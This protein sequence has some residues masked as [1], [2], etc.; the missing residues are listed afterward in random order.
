MSPVDDARYNSRYSMAVKRR[1]CTAETREKVLKDIQDWAQDSNAARVYWMNG[2]AGTGKTTILY[3]LCEWLAKEQRLG[4]NY[5]CSRG[6]SSCR[7]VN[8]IVPTLAYQLARYSPAFR[9]ALCKVLEEN[10]E[11]SALDVKWQF[12][13]LLQEPMQAVN[14]AMPEGV[15]IVIDGLDECDDGE[16]FRLFLE[17]ALKL[18]ADLPI[19]FFLASRPEPAIREKMLAPGYWYSILHLHD[20]EES[21]VEHDIKQYLTEALGSLYPPPSPN[22]VERLA[23]RA[24]KLFIYAATVVRYI[25]N[26]VNSSR[27]LQTVLGL[28][29]EHRSTKQHDEL[30]TLYTGILSTAI[31]PERLEGQ[32]MD[33]IWL[34]LKTVVCAKELMTVETLGSL[35]HVTEEQ[36]HSSLEPLRSIL[37]IQDIPSGL[38][39]PFHASFPDYL[40]DKLRSGD[41]HCEMT[42]H[43]DV[44]ATCCFDLMKD[45]L[46]FNICKLES[47]FVFDRDV[48]DLQDQIK[49]SIPSAL[50]YACQYWGEH[51]RQGDFTDMVHTRLIDFLTHR[52]LFWMEVLNLEQHLGIGGHMLQQIQNWLKKDSYTNTQKQIADAEAFITHFAGGACSWS[53]P[54]IYISGLAFCPKSSSVYK[55]YWQHTQGLIDIRGSAMEQWPSTAIGLWKTDSI[56]RSVAFSPNGT[57]IASGSDDHTIQ[58]WDAHT[59]NTIAGP[60]RGHTNSVNSVAFS[61]DGAYIVSGSSDNTIRVWDISTGN[62][63]AGSFKGHTNRVQSVAFSPNGTLIVSG[64]EDCTIRVWDAYTGNTVAGP[65]KEHTNSV[66]SVTFSPE[67]TY[68]VSGS[69]DH[70]IRIWNTYNGSTI[71]GP[72][73]GHTN[74]VSSVAFSPDGTHIVSG[75]L[76]DTIRVWSLSTGDIVAGPFK[77]HTNWVNSVAF[78]PNGKHIVSGSSDQTIQV[79]DIHTGNNIAG[80]F[81]GHTNSVSSVAFSPSGTHIVSGSHDHTIQVWDA[82]TSSNISG[83]VKGHTD[84]VHSVAFSSDSTCIASGSSDNTVQVWDAFTGA[85]IAGPFKGHKNWINSVAFSPDNKYIVS[86]SDDHTVQVWNVQTGNTIAGP[87]KGHTDLVNSV[88]FSPNGTCI[89]SGSD[90]HTIQVWDV[91]TGNNI[92][93]PFKGHTNSVSSVAFSPSGKHIVSGS[94]DHTIRVW[95]IHTGKTIAGPFRGHTD[96]VRSVAFSPNSMQ[97]VS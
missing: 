6:S 73:K 32:E 93:G 12:Q 52:L 60:F 91:H 19:K 58:V 18:A 45:K 66:N 71:A 78:S 23:K 50:S 88:V 62:T 97:I 59:G 33:E 84:W 14:T 4:A 3:S 94:N 54:H 90:D 74:S 65:F 2:M 95:D 47:S 81:K 96:W 89:I 15:V 39:S 44:L 75:S 34:T 85:S 42:K 76:D 70:T 35:L 37:H 53:T 26:G 79:W 77:G 86:G 27:R 22:D 36:V 67:G 13:K 72:F 57:C 63:V 7:D 24:G 5:F 61:P 83:L 68:I 56:V 29:P 10:P 92:A 64:S 48:L 1:G 43:N 80:P 17:T 9:S 30:D 87:F 11:A 82:H 31:D 69:D 46:K 40:F 49:K 21:V 38:V 20:I 41:F 25:Q 16:A 55:N 51:L 8:H 28:V